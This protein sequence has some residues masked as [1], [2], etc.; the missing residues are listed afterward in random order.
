M[1]EAMDRIERV[2]EIKCVKCDHFTKHTIQGAYDT[3]WHDDEKNY[4][5][6]YEHDLLSCNGC[7][8]VTYRRKTWICGEPGPEEFF[9]PRK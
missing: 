9:P 4:G 6:D 5:E 7:A 8:E 2:E 1:A 3:G